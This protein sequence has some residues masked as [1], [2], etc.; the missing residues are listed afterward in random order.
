MVRSLNVLPR[1]GDSRPARNPRRTGVFVDFPQSM[2]DSFPMRW[3]DSSSRSGKASRLLAVIL[4]MMWSIV[5]AVCASHAELAL[6]YSTE[7]SGDHHDGDHHRQDQDKCCHSLA[8]A[9]FLTASAVVAPPVKVVIVSV[10]AIV[11][12][13]QRA[14]AA[15]ESQTVHRATGPPRTLPRRFLTYSALAPPVPAA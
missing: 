1:S 13:D 8:N 2:S 6:S 7:A 15:L 5:P 11:V 4:V 14:T 10:N 12:E 9:K 3:R